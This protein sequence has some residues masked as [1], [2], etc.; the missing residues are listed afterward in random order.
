MSVQ[1]R[2]HLLCGVAPAFLCLIFSSCAFLNTLFPPEQ[3]P[4]GGRNRSLLYIYES[5]DITAQEY[6]LFLEGREYSLDIIHMSDITFT[7]LTSYGVL[8]AG[9]DTGSSGGWGTDENISR[10][11]SSGRPVIGVWE[12]GVSL[13]GTFGLSIG[14]TDRSAFGDGSLYVV[15]DRHPIF[16]EPDVIDIPS[17]HVIYL[18]SVTLSMGINEGSLSPIVFRYGR[19]VSSQNYYTLLQEDRF[20]FWGYSASPDLF[21]ETGKDLFCN[22]V[23]FMNTY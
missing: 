11:K 7:D 5:D 9:P 17:T 12:G 14:G 10:V 1:G 19:N 23:N 2:W 13:F 3:V 4:F 20:F 21:T 16:N 8:I 22:I 15:D 18:C 6:R